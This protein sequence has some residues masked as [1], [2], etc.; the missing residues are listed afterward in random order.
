MTV[1]ANDDVNHCTFC[2][3]SCIQGIVYTILF[4]EHV[5]IYQSIKVKMF[6]SNIM[7]YI[8]NQ[9]IISVLLCQEPI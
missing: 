7:P 8:T 3:V 2:I 1:L 9:N 6:D 5:Q 4:N